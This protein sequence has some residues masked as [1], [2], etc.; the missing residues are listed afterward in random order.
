MNSLF[1]I[2]YI[3]YVSSLSGDRIP[4]VE[5]TNDELKT[6]NLI[7]KELMDLYPTHACREHIEAIKNLEKNGL[8]G[9]NEIP[10]LEDVSNFL[11]SY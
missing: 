2:F 11:K 6:W 3:L 8:Y 4:R 10:Q 1:E 9:P 5:Y 7:Y